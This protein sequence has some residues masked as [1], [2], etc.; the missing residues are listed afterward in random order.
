MLRKLQEKIRKR[1]KRKYEMNLN[2]FD[3]VEVGFSTSVKM[4]S[5]KS[6]CGLPKLAS[7]VNANDNKLPVCEAANC[8]SKIVERKKSSRRSH[9]ATPVFLQ[10]QLTLKMQKSC[11]YRETTH[12]ANT[13]VSLNGFETVHIRV[14]E[15][16]QCG[17]NISN[18]K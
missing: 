2:F 12:E 9:H 16:L 10:H 15:R 1:R 14:Y 11:Q 4:H 17:Q 8:G 7:Y 6:A 5:L 3:L 18:L 13:R